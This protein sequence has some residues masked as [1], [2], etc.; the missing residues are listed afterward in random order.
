M[1]AANATTTKQSDY[2]TTDGRKWHWLTLAIPYIAAL[3][4]IVYWAFSSEFKVSNLPALT[5]VLALAFGTTFALLPTLYWWRESWR[6][7]EWLASQKL[8]PEDREFEKERFKTN[9]DHARAF[10]PAVITI[11][12]AYVLTSKS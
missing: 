8:S 12:V 3:L 5:R 4:G 7:E 11:F 9:R 1:A 6:F 10:W 2:W